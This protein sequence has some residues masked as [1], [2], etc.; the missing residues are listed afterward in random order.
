MKKT[1]MICTLIISLFHFAGS[2]LATTMKFQPDAFALNSLDHSYA[3]KWGV[4]FTIPEG[5]KISSLQI[6]FNHFRNWDNETNVLYVHLLASADDGVTEIIDY[7]DGNYDFFEGQGIELFTLHD[8][9]SQPR[10]ITHSFTEGQLD[11]LM[12]YAVDGNIGIGLDPDCH[13]WSDGIF[14]KAEF[15]PV[16][17]VPEPATL[18]LLGPGMLGLGYYLRR[19]KK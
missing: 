10:F 12:K 14:L 17:S 4:N 13:F 8:I 2:A 9:S 6:E 3:Y 5:Q 7:T 1:L 16:Q 15:V 11:T 19:I 18:L